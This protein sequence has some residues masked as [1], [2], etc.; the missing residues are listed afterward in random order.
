[1]KDQASSVEG[2]LLGPAIKKLRTEMGLSQADFAR[3]IGVAPNSIYRYESGLSVPSTT[4]LRNLYGW[5]VERKHSSAEAAFSDE[6]MGRI[7]FDP[8]GVQ[9][10][11][12]SSQEALIQALRGLN[13]DDTMYVIV[14]AKLLKGGLDK[15]AETTI[16]FLLKRWLAEAKAEHEKL[17]KGPRRITVE[18][19]SPGFANGPKTKKPKRNPKS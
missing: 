15:T 18:D 19:V 8:A 12:S 1:M 17:A 5:A 10:L 14:F 16:K 11:S 13:R 7:G 3:M 4:V 2:R 6:L 9:G